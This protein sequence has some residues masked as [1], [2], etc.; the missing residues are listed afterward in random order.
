MPGVK[1]RFAKPLYSVKLYRGFDKSAKPIWTH[2]VR[3]KGEGQDGPSLSLS[4]LSDRSK[5]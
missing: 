4:R 2:E 5:F 1:R 3:P